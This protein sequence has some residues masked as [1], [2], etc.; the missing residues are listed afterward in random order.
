MAEVKQ[1]K[2]DLEDHLREQISF[3]RASADSYDSGFK[4][5]AKRLAVII[6]VLLHDTHKSTSLMTLLG[7]KGI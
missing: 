2:V 4:G 3:L 7:I 6:R 5:E 1:S